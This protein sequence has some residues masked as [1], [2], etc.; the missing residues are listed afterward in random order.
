MTA[1]HITS[2]VVTSELQAHRVGPRAVRVPSIT[3]AS[4][5]GK[6][7]HTRRSIWRALPVVRGLHPR[8]AGPAPSW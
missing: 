7:T 3:P 4:G 2:L 1:T 5:D 6:A 8:T